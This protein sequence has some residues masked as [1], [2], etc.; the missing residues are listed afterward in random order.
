MTSPKAA[1]HRSTSPV[2]THT[3]ATSRG[4]H[5]SLRS[6][7][8]H[9]LALTGRFAVGGGLGTLGAL[10][11]FG[12]DSLQRASRA[13]GHPGSIGYLSHFVWALMTSCESTAL[14]KTTKNWQ[15]P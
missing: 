2:A 6:R 12:T 5:S 10:P 11:G 8:R 4:H 13:F 15:R 14:T 7:Q 1:S 9:P 3:I